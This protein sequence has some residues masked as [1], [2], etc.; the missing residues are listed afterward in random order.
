MYT[1]QSRLT[2]DQCE[3]DNEKIVC[4]D[5]ELIEFVDHHELTL[6]ITRLWTIK[7]SYIK[8][9]GEGLT[10]N[11]SK[12]NF[13]NCYDEQFKKYGYTFKVFIFENYCLTACGEFHDVQIKRV[14][15]DHF[16]KI[17]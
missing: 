15:L 4:T 17:A 10:E 8:C 14:S 12:Y 3:H 11:I 1:S 13:A 5:Y 16:K 9:I 2:T 6:K 7:E